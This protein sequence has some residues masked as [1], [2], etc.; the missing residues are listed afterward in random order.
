VKSIDL[1]DI[2]RV[3]IERHADNNHACDVIVK[4][5]EGTVFTCLFVTL[6]YLRRQMEINYLFCK[7]VEDSVPVRFAALDTPHL[8]VEKL[9]RDTIEDT[10]DNLVALDIFETLFTRV[11]ERE[12]DPTAKTTRDA[13]R[14]TQEVAAVVISDVL[15]VSG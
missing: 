7:Q 10:I 14:T 13:G 11:T 12:G 4:M 9:D 2:D 1:P 15:V 5:T 3:Y 6:N 8:L